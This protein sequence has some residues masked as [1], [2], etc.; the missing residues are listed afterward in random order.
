VTVS[1]TA[2][3]NFLGKAEV[4]TGVHTSISKAWEKNESKTTSEQVLEGFTQELSQQPGTTAILTYIPQY[5]C[6][7]GTA[8]CGKDKHGKKIV[9]EN[10]KVCTAVKD[11][12]AG[13]YQVVYTSD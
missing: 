7:Q 5:V 6:D 13:R 2:G 1:V 8:E 3:V 9:L 12:N 10:F 11:V 4:E